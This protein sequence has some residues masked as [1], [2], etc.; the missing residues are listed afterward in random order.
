MVGP[1][2]R[3][4]RTL[5]LRVLPPEVTGLWWGAP[6][7]GLLV[8]DG[9]KL[10]TFEVVYNPDGPLGSGLNTSVIA[11]KDA[12]VHTLDHAILVFIDHSPLDG[13]TYR[14]RG[15]DANRTV[16]RSL[17]VEVKAPAAINAGS[18]IGVD[19]SGADATF[20]WTD[21]WVPRADRQLIVIHR[22]GGGGLTVDFTNIFEVPGAANIWWEGFNQKRVF[23]GAD[24]IPTGRLWWTVWAVDKDGFVY[25]APRPAIEGFRR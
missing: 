4:P 7:M 21:T 1:I 9:H 16:M 22:D 24:R 14:I 13:S 25:D 6:R 3:P 11:H 10:A 19:V 5:F 8:G 12:N 2:S 15:H 17:P 18:L 20:R 23:H